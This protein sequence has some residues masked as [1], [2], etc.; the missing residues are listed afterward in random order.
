MTFS[1]DDYL[2]RDGLE[3]LAGQTRGR[4]LQ[5]SAGTGAGVFERLNRELSGYYLIGFEP[6]AADRTGRQRRIKLQVRRRGLDV[7]ARPTFA[8]E[9][10]DSG[11]GGDRRR[12]TGARARGGGQGPPGLAAARSGHPDARGHLQRR[13]APRATEV[14]VIVAAEVGEPAARARGVA[15]RHPGHGQERQADG[16]HGRPHDSLAGHAAP[17]LAAPAAD[18]GAARARRVHP[19]PRRR[20]R[21]RPHR[22]RA[23]HDSRRR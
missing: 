10:R 1:F 15:D 18:H 16:R 12:G 21:R 8:L 20:R 6:T 23:P 4:L 13:R 2:M 19:A 3:Q 22:Q 9:P 14:R 5:V 17:G 11:D 7:R